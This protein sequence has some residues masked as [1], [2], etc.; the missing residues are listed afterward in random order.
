[1]A[2]PI[3]VWGGEVFPKSRKKELSD[4]QEPA[5][6]TGGQ[7]YSELRTRAQM[8]LKKVEE[9]GKQSFFRVLNE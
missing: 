5:M 9:V 7:I 1:M 6:P 3:L 8:M 2:M 4:K